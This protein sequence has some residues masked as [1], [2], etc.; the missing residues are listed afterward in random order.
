[1]VWPGGPGSPFEGVRVSPH[2]RAGQGWQW[3]PTP[4]LPL[5]GASPP[6]ASMHAAHSPPTV[7]QQAG[8]QHDTHA[9]R[10][11]RDERVLPQAQHQP[12]GLRC[13]GGTEH[14]RVRGA[15]CMCRGTE[16]GQVHGA[17]C[18][19]RGMEHAACAG[20]WTM[21]HEQACEAG[22]LKSGCKQQGQLHMGAPVPPDLHQ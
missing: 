12:L 9:A 21:L 15:C 2:R 6:V 17:C 19:C 3:L 18:V 1:M 4:A 20:A 11:L 16:H 14:G 8:D 22:L 7:H 5:T 10:V 13:A